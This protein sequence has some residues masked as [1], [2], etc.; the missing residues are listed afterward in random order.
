M[1]KTNPTTTETMFDH[2]YKDK[3]SCLDAAYERSAIHAGLVNSDDA[4]F[5]E[6][7]TFKES[8]WMPNTVKERHEVIKDR[9]PVHRPSHYTYGTIEAINVIEDWKLNFDMG[10]ALKYIARAGHKENKQ[11][12][13]EKAIW[14]LE[15]ELNHA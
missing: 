3:P 13:L 14:Y 5:H 12:D 9:D 7:R 2:F 1:F 4:K 8:K 10:N 15:R 11:Q 6:N